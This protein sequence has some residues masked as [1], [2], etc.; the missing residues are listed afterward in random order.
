MR[1]MVVKRWISLGTILFDWL[2][3]CG[4]M[5]RMLARV[6]SIVISV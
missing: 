6:Q 5:G 4:I 3:N 1:R 2:S